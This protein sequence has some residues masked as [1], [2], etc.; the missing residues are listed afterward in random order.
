[1]TT[2]DYQIKL[3]KIETDHQESALGIE[4]G[5]HRLYQAFIQTNCGVGL[6]SQ[7]DK[8]GR[9]VKDIRG[10]V[11]QTKQSGITTLMAQSE[12]LSIRVDLQRM[13][14]D[15]VT[16]LRLRR[17]NEKSRRHDQGV[18]LAKRLINQVTV[19]IKRLQDIANDEGTPESYRAQA[20]MEAIRGYLVLMAKIFAASGR[21]FTSDDSESLAGLFDTAV[22]VKNEF[23]RLNDMGNELEAQLLM[24]E[25][26]ATLQRLEESGAIV[27]D[28][29]ARA[30]RFGLTSIRNRAARFLSG[31]SIIG[32]RWTPLSRQI[33]ILPSVTTAP[34]LLGLILPS[35]S[36]GASSS[37]GAGRSS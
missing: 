22:G 9:L 32:L 34:P 35:H 21:S 36:R 6:T 3:A 13:V 17:F 28:I 12:L 29:L 4:L 7:P 31:Q 20:R 33:F 15:L 18:E 8:V 16:E 24:A 5:L 10:M 14:K 26:L 19:W 25:I 23:T 1:M 30:E 27:T 2:D 37:E 11:A